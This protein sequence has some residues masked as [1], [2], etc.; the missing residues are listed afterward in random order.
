MG[1]GGCP[2]KCYG[3]LYCGGVAGY[4]ETTIM[5]TACYCSGFCSGSGL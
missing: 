3:A 2:G 4:G 5:L 1:G